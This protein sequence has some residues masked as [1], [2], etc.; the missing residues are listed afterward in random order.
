[1]DNIKALEMD[2]YI[3]AILIS[4]WEGVKKPDPMIFRRVT[5][6]LHVTPEDCVFIGDHPGKDIKAARE[7]GMKGIWKRN[8]QWYGAEADDVMDGLGEIPGVILQLNSV[9]HGTV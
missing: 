7:V 8:D 9:S 2:S 6:R 1:M 3:D 5:E 4:D